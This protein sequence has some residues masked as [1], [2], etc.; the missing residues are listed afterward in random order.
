MVYGFPHI[1]QDEETHTCAESAL[2]SHIEYFGSRYPLQ[3]LIIPHLNCAVW[4]LN[5]ILL[6]CRYICFLPP[7]KHIL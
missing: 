5:L 6:H 2:W 3:L 1:V 4:L 7:K